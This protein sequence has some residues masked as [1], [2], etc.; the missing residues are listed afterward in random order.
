VNIAS[1][2]SS[3]HGIQ[4]KLAGG[5]LNPGSFELV[6]QAVGPSLNGVRIGKFFLG[7]DGLSVEHGVTAHDEA[8][9]MAA[10]VI[11]EHSDS[12]FVLADSQ[13]FKKASFAQVA[14]ITA[15]EAIVTTNKTPRG[16]RA[17][18][19]EAGVRVVVA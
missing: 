9:A 5:R 7:T 3:L 19:E 11:M 10:R 13:K 6:G 14:P 2:L 18:L 15:I 1:E 12:T 8:E 16:I 4:V 17:Q